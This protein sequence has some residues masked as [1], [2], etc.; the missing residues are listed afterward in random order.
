MTTWQR[1]L[2]LIGF[3]SIA[4][5]V[6]AAQ[7][8]L[9][10]QLWH[11]GHVIVVLQHGNAQHRHYQI[12]RVL[13]GDMHRIVLRDGSVLDVDDSLWKLLGQVPVPGNTAVMF[14]TARE[15]MPPGHDVTGLYPLDQQNTF[16]YAAE[17]TSVRKTLNV[18]QLEEL[19]A[20]PPFNTRACVKSERVAD[21]LLCTGETGQGRLYHHGMEVSGTEDGQIITANPPDT[22]PLFIYRKPAETGGWQRVK[23]F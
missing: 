16:T 19:L 2:A 7:P 4:P 9:E 15:I 18:L 13:K 3:H 8:P 10:Y 17:D 5:A 14:L 23:N 21:Y 12:E 11:A 20:R 22:T 1:L 6:V